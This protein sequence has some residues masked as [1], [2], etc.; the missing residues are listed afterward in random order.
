M[1]CS[2][3][4]VGTHL[5]GLKCVWWQSQQAKYVVA[6]ERNIFSKNRVYKSCFYVALDPLVYVFWDKNV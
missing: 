3:N 2:P 6:A 5:L 1:S 4:F